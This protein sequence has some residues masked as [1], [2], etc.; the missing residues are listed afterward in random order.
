MEYIKKIIQADPK[1]MNK[2][3]INIME[4]NQHYWKKFV[5][6]DE[7]FKWLCNFSNEDEIYLALVLANNILYHNLDE[8]RSLWKRILMNRVKLFLLDEI[9]GDRELPDIEKWFQEYLREK[10]IFVGYGRAGK[11]GQSMVYFFK[12]SH[13]VRELKYMEFFEFLH[14]SED[15]STKE[16]VF[17]LDDFIGTGNQAKTTWYNKIDGKSFND[18]Y[19]ENP[20]LKFIYLAMVGFKEGKKVIE[21]NTPMK[22]ILGEE[23]DERFKCFSNVSVIYEDP[24]ERSRAR[25]VMEK[26]GRILYKYPLGYDNMELA[27]AFCHNT[28]NNSLPVIWKRMDDGTWY[29]LFERFE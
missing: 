8:V 3:F 22:A 18:I 25:E 1:R 5:G 9:F 17:L 26:K 19:E 7:I 11:S 23:L 12:Q 24:N 20:H 16:N 2:I 15:F 13:N 21:E 29:P 10:C 27:V 28:P 6:P 4:K 14:S